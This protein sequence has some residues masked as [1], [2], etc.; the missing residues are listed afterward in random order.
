MASNQRGAAPAIAD[1]GVKL[2]KLVELEEGP[3]AMEAML[4]DRKG[5]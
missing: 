3:T 5:R 1:L 4:K 2:P